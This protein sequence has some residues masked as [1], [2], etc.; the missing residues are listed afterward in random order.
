V[1]YIH[2]LESTEDCAQRVAFFDELKT[3]QRIQG[4]GEDIERLVAFHHTSDCAFILTQVGGPVLRTDRGAE[5]LTLQSIPTP[6]DVELSMDQR[7]FQLLRQGR[8]RGAL[9]RF[10]A[11]YE[12]SPLNRRAYLG[13]IVAA[14]LLGALPLAE[15]AALMGS[16]ILDSDPDLQYHL[17]AVL[18]RQHRWAD[19]EEAL[20]KLE[21]LAPDDPRLHLVRAVLSTGRH[22]YRR[23]AKGLRRGSVQEGLPRQLHTTY[24]NLLGQLL[25]RRILL[26]TGAS[27]T[28]CGLLSS[29]WIGGWGMGIA[30]TGSMI[31]LSSVH[32]CRRLFLRSLGN[33][34]SQGLRL[35]DI[36]CLARGRPTG[37]AQA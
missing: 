34:G 25:L 6:A 12:S 3:L 20:Q 33:P 19:A 4:G 7:A 31:A 9:R 2:C 22:R 11:A 36:A 35:V 32:A 1:V 16:R 8:H 21:L 18:L 17:V 5:F 29:F 13:A 26:W 37:L 23:A 15:G 10:I 30:L 28:I 14:D 27:I 24:R